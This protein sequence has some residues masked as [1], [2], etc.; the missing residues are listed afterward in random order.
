ML[1]GLIA[2]AMCAVVWT[3][4]GPS[5]PFASYDPPPAFAIH[6]TLA[7]QTGLYYP[8]AAGTGSSLTGA[9]VVDIVGTAFTP[10][11]GS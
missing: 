11:G 7:S 1:C 8:A 2:L 10:T 4:C 6:Y 3:A 5:A 9:Y